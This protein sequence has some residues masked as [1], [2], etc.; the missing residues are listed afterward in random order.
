MKEELVSFKGV[1]DGVRICL[2]R[3]APMYSLLDE[4]ERK[5]S[6][7]KSFFGD[8][9]CVIRFSGRTLAGSEKPRLEA[10]VKRLL[11][12][13]RI[14]FDEPAKRAVPSND[15]ILEY[16]R[17]AGGLESTVHPAEPVMEH[18]EQAAGNP[19]HEEFLSVF[20][21]DRARFYQG[22][23]HDGAELHSD[24][25]LVLLGTV[26]EGAA[27][28]AV[29]N[30]LVFGGMYGSA[31]AG[32]NGHNGSYIM[33]M[34]MHP[35]RLAIAGASEMF[36]YEEPEIEVEP[37]P[38]KKG[39]F[40]FRKKGGEQPKTEEKREPEL[41]SAVALCKNNKIILDNFTIQTFTNSKNVL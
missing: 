11:P 30:I 4:L 9:N 20:R 21:S 12:L 2:D 31:H 19:G 25:H 6:D 17:N 15:W 13:G 26:E 29:G 32:C 10:L 1:G 28:S 3:S 37:E 27:V 34:D 33:A 18:K 36:T 39:L 41:N 5:I 35:Q 38:V 14:V 24:G 40:K 23:L 16:K 8:G 7:S 22:F